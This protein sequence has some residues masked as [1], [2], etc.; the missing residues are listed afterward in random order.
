LALLLRFRRALALSSIASTGQCAII[1]G[2]SC[3]QRVKIQSMPNFTSTIQPLPSNS[4]ATGTL[5]PRRIRGLATGGPAR[6]WFDFL[7]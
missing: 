5:L 4:A 1:L 7:H 2:R 3:Q 6:K